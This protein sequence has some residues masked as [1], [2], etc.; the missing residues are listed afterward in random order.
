MQIIK[1]KAALAAGYSR[2]YTG[3][4][5]SREHIDERDAP[6]GRC[7]SCIRE[8]TTERYAKHRNSILA[9][10]KLKRTSDKSYAHKCR[11]SASNYHRANKEKIAKRVKAIRCSAEY[12]ER[13]RKEYAANPSQ[14][15]ATYRWQQN[16]R[17]A[18]SSIQRRYRTRHAGRV[19]A[20]NAR[21]LNYIAAATPLWA[22][23]E[24]IR[25]V[26]ELAALNDLEVDHIV[27]LRGELV[28]GLHCEFNLQTLTKEDNLKKSNRFDPWSFVHEL[29]A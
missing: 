29:P 12:L 14:R 16:N 26:Y 28:C 22:S 5:C 4:P 11:V 3:K 27:P 24:Q 6:S 13:R 23:A 20:K 15:E 19:N 8:W 2:Y 7:L 10:I 21:R 17:E 18:V 25:S 9:A 1:R